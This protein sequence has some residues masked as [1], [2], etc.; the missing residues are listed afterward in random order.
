MPGGQPGILKEK[1]PHYLTYKSGELTPIGKG[2][3]KDTDGPKVDCEFPGTRLDAT[4]ADVSHPAEINIC[5]V[6]RG[7]EMIRYVKFI[8]IHHHTTFDSSIWILI[9]LQF[10]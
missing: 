7:N 1:R 6:T 10:W 3:L 9:I 2:Y 5:S 8:Y 4:D